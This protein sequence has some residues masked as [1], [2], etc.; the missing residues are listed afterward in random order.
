[1]EF[2]FSDIMQLDM[3]GGSSEKEEIFVENLREFLIQQQYFSGAMKKMMTKLEIL[4]EEFRVNYDHNPIHHL[5]YRLKTPKSIINK[6]NRYNLPLTLESVWDK[7]YDVAGVRV[8]CHYVKD[9]YLIR[10]LLLRQ[11]DL[12]LIRERDFIQNPKANGYRSLHMVMGIPLYLSRETAE[13]PVEIQLRTISMDF[14]A[15]LEHEIN[16]K[17]S[18]DVSDDIRYRLKMCAENIYNVEKEMQCIHKEVFKE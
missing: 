14:W 5:E 3:S 1:M 16:Y 10:E 2:S 7:L 9:I 18:E 8:I 17:F 13:V 6:L 11:D 4:D 12:R 15:S